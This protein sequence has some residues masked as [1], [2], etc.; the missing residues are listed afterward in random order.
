MGLVKLR[1]EAYSD[2]TCTSKVGQS[3]EVMFNPE[4]YERNY[5]VEYKDSK[6][7]GENNSTLLFQGV[8]GSEMKL[9]LV[10]DGT[11]VVPLPKGINSVD[12]YIQKIKDLVY[13]YKG[14]EHRPS[15]LKIIWGSLS[16]ICVCKNLKISH[17]VF[18]SDGTTLRAE[19][20]LGLA[21]TVDF[22]T[23][24]K[25]AKKNSPDLT[26]IRIVNAGD[27][28][29]LMTYRVYGD[30]SYYLDVAKINRLKSILDIKP[31][32]QLYFPP[33]KK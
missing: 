18:K 13:S 33:I 32:D 16:M 25:A 8:K 5:T 19:I 11:G 17:K 6:V 4:N 23:K 29:P 28:L 22:K 31:G 3:F 26:H 27:T 20:L 15:Y 1:I 21:E 12:S 2:P 10:A 9:K 24:A 14:S 7:A 30:S